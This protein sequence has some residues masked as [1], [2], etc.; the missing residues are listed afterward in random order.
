MASVQGIEGRYI[1]FEPSYS[2][3]DEFERLQGAQFVVDGGLGVFL[4]SLHPLLRTRA[5]H[6]FNQIPG[7]PPSLLASFLSR[8]TTPPSP[9]LSNS[10]RFS[11]TE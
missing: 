2:P 3:S 9:P 1:E 8:R 5:N 4:L 7:F 10:T 11:S 6:N